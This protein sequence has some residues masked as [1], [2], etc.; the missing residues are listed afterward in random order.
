MGKDTRHNVALS[1]HEFEALGFAAACV[2]FR[3]H[4]AM[5]ALQTDGDLEVYTAVLAGLAA[6]LATDESLWDDDETPHPFPFGSEDEKKDAIARNAARAE[7][8]LARLREEG[9]M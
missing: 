2:I 4:P 1:G 5:F 6:R 7:Q 9:R 8:D 3:Q